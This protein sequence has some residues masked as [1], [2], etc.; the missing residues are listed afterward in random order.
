[1]PEIGPLTGEPL[2]LDLINTRARLPDG[3]IDF[4]ATVQGLRHWLQCER[5]RLSTLSPR[6]ITTPTKASRLAVLDVRDHAA[7]AIERARH[8]RRPAE[9]DLGG[10]NEMMRAAPV[11]TELVRTN[12]A[13][14]VVGR[15]AGD[16][17][18]HVAAE[19]AESTAAL[20]AD[21]AV[22]TIRQCEADFCVLLF[23]PAHPRRRWCSPTICGN[24]VRV[25]RF[26][27]RLKL[28]ASG[29]D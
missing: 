26:H 24:R 15:R 4:L 10:L 5:D 8:G 27:Q 14:R 21:P 18:L 9:H 25:A 17:D 11:I 29:A 13:L 19:L 22:A 3:S 6:V 28:S 23:L 16:P 12:G 20:L 7:T 1:M 2:A